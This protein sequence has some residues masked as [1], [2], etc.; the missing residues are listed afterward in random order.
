MENSNTVMFTNTLEAR[1]NPLRNYDVTNASNLE[2]MLNISR[3]CS[4]YCYPWNNY[5]VPW[6]MVQPYGHFSCL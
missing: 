6:L 1:E 5:F 4:H 3:E 2:M